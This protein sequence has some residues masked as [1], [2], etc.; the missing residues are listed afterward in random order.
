MSLDWTGLKCSAVGA[1]MRKQPLRLD[2]TLGG[3]GGVGVG[4]VT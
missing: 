3:L 4:V 2:R 1:R